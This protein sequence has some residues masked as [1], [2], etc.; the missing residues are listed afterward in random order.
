MKDDKG[1]G[2]HKSE[3]SV[4]FKFRFLDAFYDLFD[5]VFIFHGKS[6]PRFSPAKEISNEHLRILDS[7]YGFGF[8]VAGKIRCLFSQVITA[9]KISH[10][11]DL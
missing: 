9:T 3:G 10:T 11:T 2:D 4:G 5:L 6:N 1:I 8:R 7:V